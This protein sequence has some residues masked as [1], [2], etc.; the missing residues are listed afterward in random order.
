MWRE[1]AVLCLCIYMSALVLVQRVCECVCVGA[2][3]VFVPECITAVK[4]RECDT[5][6]M[7]EWV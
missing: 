2:C 7:R 1:L 6:R 5:S 4:K 3:V